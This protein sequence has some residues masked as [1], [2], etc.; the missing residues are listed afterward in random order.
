MAQVT[1]ENNVK[2]ERLLTSNPE[3]EKKVRKI[4]RQVL[5]GAQK[6]VQDDAK[7]LSTRQAYK[8]VRSSVY[9]KVLGGNLNILD[10]KKGVT[11]PVPPSSRGRLARTEQIMSYQ[12]ESRGFILRFLNSG[13]NGRVTTNMNGHPI[14]RSQKVKW[15][16]YKSGEIGGRGRIA[17]RN[18]FG[19]AASQELNRT[20]EEFDKLLDV[21]IEKEFNSK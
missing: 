16:N 14:Y 5:K 3:M 11:A 18:W 21:L 1:I 6:G 13:T 10:G 4:V 20:A 12:G 2:L 17:A 15:H 7:S 19:P 8:A 9:K